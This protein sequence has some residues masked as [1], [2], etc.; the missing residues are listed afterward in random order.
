MLVVPLVEPTFLLAVDRIIGR[1]KVEHDFF[2]SLLMGRQ[3]TLHQQLRH[4]DQRLA[5]HAILQAAKRL[6]SEGAFLY[7]PYGSLAE[8]VFPRTGNLH[9][10]IKKIKGILDPNNVMNPGRLAL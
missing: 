7:R 5:I 4:L 2:R 3:E 8:M 1:I 9:E 6:L 10:S